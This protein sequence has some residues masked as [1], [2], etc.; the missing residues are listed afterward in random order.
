MLLVNRFD[1]PYSV[2]LRLDGLLASEAVSRVERAWEEAVSLAQGRKLVL[3]VSGITHI[4]PAGE[5]FLRRLHRAGTR[6][7]DDGRYFPRP[8]A[9]PPCALA[10]RVRLRLCAVVCALMPIFHRCPCGQ[11][12]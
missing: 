10:E 5:D 9:Q 12:L 3:D 1:E 2:R 7:D 11:H 6:I 4:D 8:C